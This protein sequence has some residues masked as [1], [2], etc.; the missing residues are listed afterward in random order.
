MGPDGLNHQNDS[1]LFP[2]TVHAPHG[3]V[4]TLAELID[5]ALSKLVIVGDKTAN[6]DIRVNSA[7]LERAFR[8]VVSFYM[9]RA[10][11][12]ERERIR[13][14]LIRHG[15]KEAQHAIMDGAE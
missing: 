8:K 12:N 9:K 2:P 15:M 10:A 14:A 7:S 5:E 13:L 11:L 1:V 6:V 3:P 4:K